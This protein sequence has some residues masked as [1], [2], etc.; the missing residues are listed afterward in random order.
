MSNRI[1]GVFQSSI[2]KF[3]NFETALSLVEERHPQG[4]RRAMFH[5]DEGLYWVVSGRD[6]KKLTEA[7]YEQVA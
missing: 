5:G 4:Y 3:N 2:S 6:I 1:N 7:Q